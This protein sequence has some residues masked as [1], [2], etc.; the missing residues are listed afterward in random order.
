[1]RK[2]HILFTLKTL[3]KIEKAWYNNKAVGRES[4]SESPESTASWE[5]RRAFWMKQS[6]GSG[7]EI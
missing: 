5:K 1:M 3:D 6:E 2:Y 7:A 4:E